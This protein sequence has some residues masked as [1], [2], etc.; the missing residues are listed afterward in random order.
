MWSEN[1]TKCDKIIGGCENNQA[2]KKNNLST[3]VLPKPVV[4]CG[5]FYDGRVNRPVVE[6]DTF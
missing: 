5:T 2:I 6:C 3:M 4:E 1:D